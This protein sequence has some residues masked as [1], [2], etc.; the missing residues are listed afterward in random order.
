MKT[1]IVILNWN[2]EKMLQCFLPSVVKN[3]RI[4][5]T[6]IIVSDNGSTD[7]SI[8]F[9]KDNFSEVKI[10]ELKKN[11]GFAEGYNRTLKQID[12]DYF[13][14]LN[15]DVEV[16][17]GWLNPLIELMDKDPKVAAVQP[18]ILNWKKK[19]EFEYA[20]AAGGFID[21]L[22]FP[23]CRG[24][25]LD[26]MEKDHGQYDNVTSIFWASGACMAIKANYFN[27]AGGFDSDFWAHM[28]EIDL[29]WRLKNK[30]FKILFTPD[31]SVYHL[32]GGTLPYNNPFKLFLNFRNSLWLLHKNLPSGKFIRILITRLLLD[33]AGALRWLI[34]GEFKDFLSVVKAHLAYYRSLPVIIKK[35]KKLKIITSQKWHP[36]IIC[37][38][39][40][41]KYYF[42]RKKHFNEI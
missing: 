32:G 20:G 5:D 17:P 30:G 34:T 40:I 27:E 22:G 28:E 14:L 1:A 29:C 26:I 6:E 37:R 41:F 16:T 23:L 21:K 18:K 25:V 4:K 15:S 24:R 11:Y 42:E 2:G 3:S 38:S 33:D 31:S 13:V 36:E 7:S 9:I 10:I 35:R 12:A 8:A 19:D 39:I